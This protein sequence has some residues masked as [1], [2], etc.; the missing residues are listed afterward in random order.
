M[1]KLLK[2]S[3]EISR[4][5]SR[6]RHHQSLTGLYQVSILTYRMIWCFRIFTKKK[7]RKKYIVYKCI[8][9]KNIL[10][11]YLQSDAKEV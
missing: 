1:I 5:Y 3:K 2:E 7:T 8:K 11:T 9:I 10:L 6:R 4:H